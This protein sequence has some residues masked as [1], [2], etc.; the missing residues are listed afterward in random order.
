MATISDFGVSHELGLV[1]RR[2][3]ESLASEE[4]LLTEIAEYVIASGGKRVRP[5]VTLLAFKAVGG[6]ALAKAVDIAAALEL[7]HSASLIHDDINDGGTERRGRPAAYLK[8][9]MQEALVTGDFMFTK[10]FRIGGKFDDEIVDMTA[11]VAAALAEGEIR[12][13]RHI[14]NVSLTSEEY[15]DIVTRKTA[16]PIATGARVGALLGDGRLDQIEAAGA[17]GLN[18]GIA[19][20]IV[21]DILDV[22]GDG[23]ALGKRP[24]MDIK[25]GN[26]TVLSIHAL[27]DGN[28]SDRSELIRILRKRSKDWGEVQTARRLIQESGAVEKARGDARGFGDRAVTALEGLPDVEARRQM[29]DLVEF[30][31]SR[32]S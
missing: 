27:Q 22:V 4:P 17:Y 29:R 14:G 26:I 6:R 30:V 12:Q 25:E 5:L 10:A 32:D 20:Q 18:L 8:F 28:V 23:A 2:I 16:M 3:R 24:G 9:G 21:D 11:R 1:E 31:L 13:K 19:F 7:I 15:L